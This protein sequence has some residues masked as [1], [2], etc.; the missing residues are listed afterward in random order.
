MNILVYANS[1][2]KHGLEA[3]LFVKRFLR[4]F[5]DDN[6]SLWDKRIG[7]ISI[8]NDEFD[9]LYMEEGIKFVL[10]QPE[11]VNYNGTI[12]FRQ[13]F[14]DLDIQSCVTYKFWSGLPCKWLYLI[15][16]EWMKYILGCKTD[17]ELMMLLEKLFETLLECRVNLHGVL[18]K[19]KIKY[20]KK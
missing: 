8:V 10:V 9:R 13:F 18:T 5:I 2:Q 15:V 12:G 17:D 19:L 20:L 1:L 16:N 3:Q 4:A 14:L 11:Q 6:I 7:D